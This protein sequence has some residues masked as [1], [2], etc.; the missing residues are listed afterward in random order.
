[1]MQEHELWWDVFFTTGHRFG[2]INLN[3]EVPD[4]QLVIGGGNSQDGVFTRLKLQTGNGLSVPT[5]S[6][7]GF[8]SL[9]VERF[10]VQHAQVPDPEF[11]LVVTTGQ[12]EL[13]SR[14]P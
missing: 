4:G 7:D 14:V 13:S 1:M 12:E 6:C 11:T 8:E 9:L 2:F 5:D 10:V 3:R